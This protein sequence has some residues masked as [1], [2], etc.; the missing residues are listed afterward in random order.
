MVFILKYWKQI[1]VALIMF[2]VMSLC[3]VIHFKN[4]TIIEMSGTIRVKNAEL[5]LSNSSIYTL[6]AEIE[7]VN[8]IIDDVHQR[9]ILTQKE[10][11]IRLAD[12]VSEKT[13]LKKQM[14]DIMAIPETGNECEDII[15]LL[16][17]L[18]EL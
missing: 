13:S 2:V 1:G 15:S 5:A 6:Q 12:L 16:D 11:A 17:N 7:K 10:T 14:A 18:G 9:Q 4:A 8:Q 3:G